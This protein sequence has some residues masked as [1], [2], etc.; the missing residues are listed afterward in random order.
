MRELRQQSTSPLIQLIQRRVIHRLGYHGID[1]ILDHPWL[2]LT[3]E[4]NLLL[5][6]QRLQ[7][8]FVPDARRDHFSRGINSEENDEERQNALLLKK[9]EVQQLFDGYDFIRPELFRN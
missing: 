1:E 8:V 2:N 5:E 7:P 3:A 6:Q 9:Y 4:E